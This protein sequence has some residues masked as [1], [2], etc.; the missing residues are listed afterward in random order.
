MYFCFR[1]CAKRRVNRPPR[2]VPV[3]APR[4]SITEGGFKDGKG[5]K[6]RRPAARTE[7]YAHVSDEQAAREETGIWWEQEDEGAYEP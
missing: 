2:V 4:Q 5:Q 7:G 1:S 6:E 3:A